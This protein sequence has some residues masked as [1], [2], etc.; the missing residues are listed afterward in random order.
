MSQEGGRVVQD[1]D[2]EPLAR[3]F[4]PKAPGQTAYRLAS[5]L[6]RQILGHEDGDV[7]ITFLA[8]VAPCA[9]SEQKRQPDLRDLGQRGGKALGGGVHRIGVHESTVP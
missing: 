8:C 9:A 5:I 1:H 3:D 4:A 6:S 7:E 2:I